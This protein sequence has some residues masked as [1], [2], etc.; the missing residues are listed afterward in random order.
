MKTFA[1]LCQLHPSYV[2]MRTEA[3]VHLCTYN[4]GR[5][6]QGDD[7]D[8]VEHQHGRQGN[9]SAQANLGLLFRV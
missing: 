2:T 1:D 5:P 3:Y 6:L 7:L 8:I 4:D 9:V